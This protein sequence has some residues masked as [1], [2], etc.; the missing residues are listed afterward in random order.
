M[1]VRPEEGFCCILWTPCTD[2][3]SMSLFSNTANVE[4]MVDTDCNNDYVE[5]NG[6]V[7]KV[8]LVHTISINLFNCRWQCNLHMWLQ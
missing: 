7:S 3:N 6:N 1:C 5:I 8:C 2:A 4:A